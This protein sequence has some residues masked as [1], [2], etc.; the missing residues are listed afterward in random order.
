[1]VVSRISAGGRISWDLVFLVLV[2][3]G[4]LSGLGW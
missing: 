3:I 1:V 4:Y 2:A